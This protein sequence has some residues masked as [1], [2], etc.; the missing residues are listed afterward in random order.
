MHTWL[1]ALCAGV[2]AQ[3]VLGEPLPLVFVTGDTPY[4]VGRGIGEALRADFAQ[5]LLN[6][7][8]FLEK[9][10][11]WARAHPAAVAAMLQHGRTAYPL[12][13]EELRGLADG[14]GLPSGNGSAAEANY[15]EI[16]SVRPEIEAFMQANLS[17]E[18]EDPK[19]RGCCDVLLRLAKHVVHGHNEDWSPQLRGLARMLSVRETFAGR[20]PRTLYGLVYPGYLLGNT[21]AWSTAG[22]SV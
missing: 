4:A 21:F 5:V 7:T 15:V 1:W 3:C 6:D 22:F 10:V 12:V 8:D 18:L 19:T 17:A 11:P 20:E 9:V 13:A 16:I 14:L 2:I